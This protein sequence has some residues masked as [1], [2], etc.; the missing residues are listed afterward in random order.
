MGPGGTEPSHPSSSL[1]SFGALAKL[2]RCVCGET[3]AVPP[4]FSHHYIKDPGIGATRRGVSWPGSS[5]LIGC[6]RALSMVSYSPLAT[7]DSLEAKHAGGRWGQEVS[8][9]S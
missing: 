7:L 9:A 8:S 6:A 4:H 5:G 3:P 2:K 1:F